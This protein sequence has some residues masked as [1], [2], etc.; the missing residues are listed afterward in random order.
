MI[1]TLAPQ[2]ASVVDPAQWSDEQKTQALRTMKAQ[3][4]ALAYAVIEHSGIKDMVIEQTT[5]RLGRKQVGLNSIDVLAA[6]IAVTLKNGSPLIHEMARMLHQD[7]PADERARRNITRPWPTGQHSR[8]E[9][10]RMIRT[11]TEAVR[12]RFESLTDA[13][14]T[15]TGPRNRKSDIATAIDFAQQQYEQDPEQAD[16]A[17]RRSSL[18]DVMN[19]VVQGSVDMVPS[20]LLAQMGDVFA[21]DGT[22]VPT[23]ARGPRGHA[24]YR[25]IMKRVSNADAAGLTGDAATAKVLKELKRQPTDRLSA[26]PEAAY[27]VRKEADG[28]EENKGFGYEAHLAVA[29]NPS[30]E[31]GTVTFPSLVVGMSLD[32]STFAPGDNA[33]SI[34]ERMQ[35][36]TKRRQRGPFKI[37][38]FDALYPGLAGATFHRPLRHLGVKPVFRLRDDKLGKAGVKYEGVSMI[39]GAWYCGEMPSN[40]VDAS[41]RHSKGLLGD[42]NYAERIEQR[43]QWQM[44]SINGTETLDQEGQPMDHR[45]ACPADRPNSKLSCIRKPDSRGVEDAPLRVA[46]VPPGQAPPKACSQRTLT[47]PHEI[48]IGLEQEH[49]YSSPEWHAVNDRYRSANEGKNGYLKDPAKIGIGTKGR[50]RVNGLAGNGLLLACQVAAG[51]LMSLASFLDHAETSADG[52]ATRTHSNYRKVRAQE[53]AAAKATQPARSSSRRRTQA[54]VDAKPARAPSARAQG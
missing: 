36:W 10:R 12:R 44:Y 41:K 43:K 22:F 52:V 6:A 45:Y 27:Y 49:P 1:A 2:S 29:L 54:K 32:A 47:I 18:L 38:V 40:L 8:D 9:Q 3:P 7:M 19:G 14:D 17:K 46:A 31:T 39:E 13:F 34:V 16:R 50:R 15:Y 5:K 48:G 20:D 53:K 28:T 30:T 51:N 35:D 24:A 25:K 4:L 21:I 11:A 23:W 37:G 33:V 26:D 42:A